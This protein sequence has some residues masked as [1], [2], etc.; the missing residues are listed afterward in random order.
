[1]Q[2]LTPCPNQPHPKQNVG[3]VSYL[4]GSQIFLCFS[5]K[6]NIP[7]CR[8]FWTSKLTLIRQQSPFISDQSTPSNVD[9]TDASNTFSQTQEDMA[10]SLA[11][12]EMSS[13]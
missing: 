5:R 1:M 9:P 2:S 12:T 4:N 7:L 8:G 11:K 13:V 10:Q 6:P 3:K